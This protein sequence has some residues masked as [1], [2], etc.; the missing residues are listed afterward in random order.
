MSKNNSIKY[1]VVINGDDKYVL[2]SDTDNPIT[3]FKYLI[4]L[5]YFDNYESLEELVLT[6]LS[7]EITSILKQKSIN[8]STDLLKLIS[9]EQIIEGIFEETIPID[10]KNAIKNLYVVFKNKPNIDSSK[11]KVELPNKVGIYDIRDII[12]WRQE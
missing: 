10:N 7:N 1:I 12:V 4:E 3:N 6:L 2:L 8:D 5:G 9:P 11:L